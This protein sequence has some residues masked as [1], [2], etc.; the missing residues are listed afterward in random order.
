MQGFLL[1]VVVVLEGLILVSLSLLLYQLVKQ[2]GRMLLRLD[3]L[4]QHTAH[5]GMI[6][7]AQ[8]QPRGLAVG[9]PIPPFSMPDLSGKMV[10]LEEFRG[11][12]VLLIN[13]SP[14]CGFCEV[15]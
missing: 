13:W 4:E 5:G 6:E 3:H 9:T 15:I 8:P 7:G 12:K 1:T 2:Q 14:E 11:K 10:S